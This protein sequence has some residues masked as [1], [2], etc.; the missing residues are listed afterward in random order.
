V[1]VADKPGAYEGFPSQVFMH[2]ALARGREKDFVGALKAARRALR[3]ARAEGRPDAGG[4]LLVMSEIASQANRLSLARRYARLAVKDAPHEWS[5]LFT[6]ARLEKE[7]ATYMDRGDAIVCYQ[8]AIEGYERA[9][10]LAEQS[11]AEPTDLEWLASDLED[12]RAALKARSAPPTK[13]DSKQADSLRD[14][15]VTL[16]QSLAAPDATKAQTAARERLLLEATRLN[17]TAPQPGKTNP[18]R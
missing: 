13:M 1:D 16:E 9:L 14:A 4:A 12:T 3:E 7:A 6:F 2:E 11:K 18:K 17:E 10:A 5:P 15:F 8:R